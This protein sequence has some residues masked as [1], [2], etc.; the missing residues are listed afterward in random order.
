MMTKL[1]I[2]FSLFVVFI[3]EYTQLNIFSASQRGDIELI[4]RLISNGKASANDRDLENITPLHW[5]SINNQYSTCKLLLD[6]GAEVDALGGELISTPLQWAA[7]F[8]LL[9]SSFIFQLNKFRNGHLYILH[10]LISNGAD[11][12]I[13]DNQGFNSLHL[14]VHSSVIMAVFYMLQQNV[15]VDTSD[16]QVRYQ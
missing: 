10:L 9:L 6:R 7:R 5:A 1:V 16:V 4:D 13:V 15:Y 3:D 11:P 2:V 14:V 8:V 12:S